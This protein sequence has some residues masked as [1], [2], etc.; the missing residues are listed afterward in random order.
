MLEPAESA[1]MVSI[2]RDGLVRF[3]HPLHAAAVRAAASAPLRR[4]V[5]AE[6][7][8]VSVDPGERARH[9]AMA[10]VGHDASVAEVLAAAAD[11][12]ARRGATQE[13][14]DL[15]DLAL[16]M[17]PDDGPLTGR[18]ID[19]ARP[20]VQRRR[21]GRRP[22]SARG[23]ARHRSGARRA[24]SRPAAV[25]RGPLRGELSRGDDPSG[26]G[27]RPGGLTATPPR[28]PPS[29]SDSRSPTGSPETSRGA[30]EH[31]ASALRLARAAARRRAARRG[32]RGRGDTELPRPGGDATT[33]SSPRRSPW[34][35][36]NASSSRSSVPVFTRP[37]CGRTPTSLGP[38]VEMFSALWDAALAAGR[39]GEL[40][41]LS[42]HRATGRSR[43]AT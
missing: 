26:R 43:A 6:L 35:T 22:R 13:A 2:D 10:T 23:G 39:I 14:V 42:L 34:R 11:E 41:F 16:R 15:A 29:T 8:A 36:R 38:G 3:E 32:T 25:G 18:R 1:G 7:A 31:Q 9:L 24:R 27:A 5:H 4:R 40:P 33:P 17:T 37:S 19:L 20:R 12:A 30:A 28:P 21:P